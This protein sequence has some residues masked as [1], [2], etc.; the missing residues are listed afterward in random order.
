MKKKAPDFYS[1]NK[2]YPF[3]LGPYFGAA[4][5]DGICTGVSWKQWTPKFVMAYKRRCQDGKGI[6]LQVRK[7]SE[8][9]NRISITFFIVDFFNKIFGACG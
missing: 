8:K 3:L 4:G 2:I 9:N 5:I 6:I 7:Y 1:G